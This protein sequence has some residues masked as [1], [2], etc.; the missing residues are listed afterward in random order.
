MISEVLYDSIVVA[1]HLEACKWPT[2]ANN[3]K[4]KPESRVP[5]G[6]YHILT[7]DGR[8]RVMRV[9]RQ[10]MRDDGYDLEAS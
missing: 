3:K 7:P 1:A 5:T 8:Q 10:V 6:A 2:G 4:A 9:E